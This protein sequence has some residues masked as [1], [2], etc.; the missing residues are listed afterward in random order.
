MKLY[1]D[2][3]LIEQEQ[4]DE[5]SAGGI[6]LPGN[7]DKPMRGLVIAVGPGMYHNGARRECSAGVGD[8]VLFGKYS[9]SPVEIEGKKYIVMRDE[10]LI[11]SV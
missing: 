5:V 7:D 1:H 4:A 6:A 8:R 3:I 11:G 10:D 9:G 2:R